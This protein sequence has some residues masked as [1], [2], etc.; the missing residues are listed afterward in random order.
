MQKAKEAGRY[1]D[2][3]GNKGSR[4]HTPP[5]LE[6]ECYE[7]FETGATLLATLGYPIFSPVVTAPTQGASEPLIY[8]CTASSTNGRGLYTPEGFVVLKG[9]IGRT[10]MT[11]AIANTAF[12]S[13][14]EKILQS[15]DVDVQGEQFVLQTDRLF[16]IPQAQQPSS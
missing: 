2:K 4:P 16:Q 8:H 9:S 6:A 12:A 5:P 13:V 7:I 10:T 1:I 15:K 3:N 14:R 11:E